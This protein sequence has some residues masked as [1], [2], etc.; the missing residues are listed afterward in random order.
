MRFLPAIVVGYLTMVSG[1]PQADAPR[2]V[3]GLTRSAI[4]GIDVAL[5]LA[6]ERRADEVRV[7]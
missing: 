4:A 2:L 5:G 6:D 1:E 3:A 7:R